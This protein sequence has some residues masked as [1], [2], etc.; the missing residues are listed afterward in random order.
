MPDLLLDWGAQLVDDGSYM[1]AMSKFDQVADLT[2]DNKLLEQAENGSLE[3]IPLLARDDG[4]DGALVISQAAAIVCEDG[5]VEDPAVD[6]Y[7]EENGKAYSCGGSGSVNIP[8]LVKADIPG[9]FR[10]VV[11]FEDK[12]R[13]VQS[14]D[15]VSSAGNRVLERWQHG[16]K[17]TILYVKNG[18]KF[19]EK[20][21][22]GNAPDPCPDERWFTMA[23]EKQYG[24]EPDE[25]AIGDWIETVIVDEWVEMVTE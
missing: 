1:L 3:I 18:A 24:D 13:R 9:T 4:S 5:V 10:Y 14:C 23:K 17:V 15:Y 19:K 21:F 16:T 25:W 11:S 22:Y 12:S 20:T 6:I 8:N 7:P 2:S